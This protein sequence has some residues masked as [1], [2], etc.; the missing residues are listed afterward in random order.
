[1][2]APLGHRST[3]GATPDDGGLASQRVRQF[4]FE[5]DALRLSM[6]WSVADL[7][8]AQVLVE[9]AAGQSHPS[10][11]HL[12]DLGTEAAKG[13]LQAGAKPAEYT[14]TDI[15]DGVAQAHDGMKYP[16]A[17]REFIANM[18]EIHAHATPFDAVVLSSSGDKAVPAHL[19]AI[20]RLDLPAVHVPGG[21]MVSGPQM[22]SNE[23]LW[24]M[25]MEVDRGKLSLEEFQAF[26]RFACPGCGACQYMGT[27]AT[28]QVMSEALGLALPWGALIPATMAELR[29]MAR[30]A[31]ERVVGLLKD[32]ITAR[33]ILTREA[34]ENAITVHAAIGGSLN[35]V[36]HL[37][38]IA[39]EAGVQITAED[40]DEIHRRTPVLVDAKTAG[41]YPTELFWY[42]GGVPRLM[43]E[44]GDRLHLDAL[45][46]SGATVG[47]N[48]ER[49]VGKHLQRQAEMFLGNYQLRAQQVIHPIDDPVYAS[50]STVLLAGNL[51]D[52]AIVKSHAVA[53]SMLTHT[54]PARVFDREE[55][56]IEAT[57][58]ESIQPG[59]VV[60]VRYQGPRATGMP[61]MF[62]L[63]ELIASN[64]VLAATTA[65]VTDGRFSGASRGPCIGY[66]HP[67]AIDGGP[68]AFL[69]DGDLVEID[70]PRRSLAVVGLAGR[71]ATAEEVE[72]AW[73][74]RRE[75]WTPP[76]VRHRGALGQYTALARPA[77]EGAG[78]RLSGPPAGS[79]GER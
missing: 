38:A 61:E 20:A 62:F 23:E 13:V 52:G 15:C 63:S 34:F 26:Q 33:T 47:E 35:A 37:I 45:T 77:L 25:K 16:L 32:G 5:G 22:R 74:S 19:L 27:A 36:M 66:A 71:R 53:E 4:S 1:M 70:I 64:P 18:V 39:D 48:L 50:G 41:R 72:R 12:A 2:S 78:C 79:A 59:D 57:V 65:L 69:E 76:V 42:A 67:E 49:L 55:D 24:S 10:S 29:R 11:Y 60:V 44:L 46:V 31:G 7:S 28:M 75:G 56:A 73:R 68:L 17:S 40:F 9:T 8:R 21:A 30:A 58:T 43:T 6:D 54:G 3:P 51:A 14:T